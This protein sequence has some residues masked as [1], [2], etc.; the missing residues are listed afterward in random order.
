MNTA[1]TAT[2]VRHPE[3]HARGRLIIHQV[4]YEQLVF[5]RNPQAAFFT[6][7]LPVMFTVVFGLV[8]GGGGADSFFYG[9]S[10]MEYFV[11]IIAALSIFGVCYGQLT[12]ILAVRRH[13][14][15]LKRLHGTPLPA[16]VYFGG[17]LATAVMISLAD[18]ALIVAAGSLFGARLPDNWPATILTLVLG[19]ASFCPL[20]VGV[21]SLI[22][23]AE[24]APAVVQF[25]QLPL[26]L[27]SG[28]FFPVHSAVLN[29]IA[30]IF[31]VRPFDQALLGPFSLHTGF[32]VHALAILLAWGV[33]G[34][35]LSVRFFRWDR[36]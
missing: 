3:L 7:A 22:R 19:V 32:D 14:G 5:W 33:A 31:P 10:A 12:L 1:L 8:F 18:V 36:S 21:A 35:V 30:G 23:N 25:V 27:I 17:L 20:G 34:T 26:F 29:D 4:K 28:N 11:P 24:A 9:L 13:T 15:I 16:W 6:F 2:R